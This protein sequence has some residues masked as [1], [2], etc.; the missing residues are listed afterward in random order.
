MELIHSLGS[1]LNKQAW[2]QDA[3][4]IVEELLVLAPMSEADLLLDLRQSLRVG[5][6][7]ALT[8][9]LFLLCRRNLEIDY[10]L[11][12]YRLRSLLTHWLK[13][14][15]S[16]EESSSQNSNL[17]SLLR[18]KYRSLAEIRCAM[19]RESFE[20]QTDFS[21]VSAADLKVV[22]CAL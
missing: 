13:L 2:R 6:D 9:D 14:E 11:P 19:V 1:S 4:K 15:I 3:V 12:F 20:H 5:Q 8:L 7:W 22:E 21:K 18:L 10:Y 17:R 16:G